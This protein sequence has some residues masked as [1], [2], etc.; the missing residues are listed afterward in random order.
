MLFAKFQPCCI[1]H[2]VLTSIMIGDAPLSL[3]S[4]TAS[5]INSLLPSCAIWHQRFNIESSDGL[6]PDSTKPLSEPMLTYIWQ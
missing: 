1:G 6:L 2:N 4:N 3:G 5:V